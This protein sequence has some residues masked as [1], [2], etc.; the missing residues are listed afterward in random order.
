MHHSVSAWDTIGAVLLLG[1]AVAMWTA[2]AVLAV[3]NRRGVRRPWV[4][5]GAVGVIG[6]GLVG[7]VGHMQEHVAQA[8]YW[9]AH[10]NTKP[11]MTPWGDSLARGYGQIDASKPSLGMEILHLVGNFIFLA[12]LAGVVLITARVRKSR[13]RRWG[14]MGVWMQ[15][16]HGLEHV[17]LTLSIALGAKRAVGLSTWFG[18]LPVGP[19]LWTYRIW[20]HG[21][22]NLVGSMVFAIAVYHL[23]QE[24]ATVQASFG[25]DT[26][27]ATDTQTV[28]EPAPVLVS[29]SVADPVAV[30]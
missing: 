28:K 13:A 12:G 19:G 16:I 17:A 6:I 8:A 20:W 2:V 18:A 7:Q 23:W 22:A 1:W 30:V 24:R 3:A 11:W 26:A 27:D 14:K 15:G 4:F 25:G 21:L 10:P 29:R 9:I 5:R